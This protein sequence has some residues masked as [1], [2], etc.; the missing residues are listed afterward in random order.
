MLAKAQN[1][2]TPNEGINAAR[3]YFNSEKATITV[4]MQSLG[5][6]RGLQIN[7]ETKGRLTKDITG[8]L[9]TVNG[10]KIAM[11]KH[12]MRDKELE[13]QLNGLV[14]DYNALLKSSSAG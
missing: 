14:D 5:K 9:M 12:T 10:L 8:N 1:G 3:A 2:A 6:V 7:E 4:T 11:L 13:A